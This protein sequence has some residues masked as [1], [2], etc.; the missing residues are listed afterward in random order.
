MSA[1]DVT[2][3]YFGVKACGCRVAV[4][5]DDPEYP[6]DTARSV[7]EFIRDG[8]TVER[9]AYNGETIGQMLKRCKC[10]A[11][12]RP[13]DSTQPELFVSPVSGA[14]SQDAKE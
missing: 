5:V 2:H 8:Y 14:V 9:A 6:K 11:G 10:K 13:P 7:A 4:V 3:V 12:S 1:H